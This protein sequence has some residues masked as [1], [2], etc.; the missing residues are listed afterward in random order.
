MDQDSNGVLIRFSDRSEAEGDIL[1]GADGAYSVVRQG[2]YEK[3]KKTNELPALDALPLPFSTVCLVGQT[4][5][6]S[7]EEFPDL[8]MDKS[9]FRNF[10]ATDKI[11]SVSIFFLGR[12]N[13]VV[14][15][16]CLL[17]SNIYTL[18]LIVHC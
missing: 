7:A 3:L 11:Y 13:R 15:C 18:F 9:Q 16:F 5:P 2:L 8:A 17:N 12:R 14:P 10:I 1:V 4:R 6:M